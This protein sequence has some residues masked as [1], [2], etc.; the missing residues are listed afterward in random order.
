[1]VRLLQH[2]TN[3]QLTLRPP[4]A[5]SPLSLPFSPPPPPQPT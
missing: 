4:P 5:T 3:N 2:N 1:M